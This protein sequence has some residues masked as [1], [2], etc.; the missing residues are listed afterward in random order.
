MHPVG[1]TG[2]FKGTGYLLFGELLTQTDVAAQGIIEQIRCLGNIA[3][4]VVK[5]AAVDV[6]ELLAVEQNITAVIRIILEEQ[7]GQCGFSASAFTRETNLFLST[8][9]GSVRKDIAGEVTK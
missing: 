4:P 1:Q 7:L 2:S 5:T 6:P 9:K 8:K 3:C